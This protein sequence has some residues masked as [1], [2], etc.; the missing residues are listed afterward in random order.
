MFVL[1]KA[2]SPTKSSSTANAKH[3]AHGANAA[4]AGVDLCARQ[5]S[6]RGAEAEAQVTSPLKLIFNKALKK[7]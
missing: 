2:V 3:T 5:A 1:V 7:V 6:W 4:T